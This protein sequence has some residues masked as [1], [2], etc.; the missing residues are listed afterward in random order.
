MTA[1][2][3]MYYP[4]AVPKHAAP[5]PG[6]PLADDNSPAS[7]I[8]RVKSQRLQLAALLPIEVVQP[9][10]PSSMSGRVSHAITHRSTRSKL[11]AL[12]QVTQTLYAPPCVAP[13]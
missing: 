7:T 2:L 1:A 8:I 10:T 9:S 12:E 13:P 4:F 3:A 6:Q 11:P 5:R